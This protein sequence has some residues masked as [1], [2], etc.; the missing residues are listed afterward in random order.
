MIIELD[1]EVFAAQPHALELYQLFRLAFE[2]RHLLLVRP[3][4][5]SG[6]GPA[7]E[8]WLG[9]HDL[10]LRELLQLVLEQ[11]ENDYATGPS[12]A[13]QWTVRVVANGGRAW[14]VEPPEL[15]LEVACKLAESP[16]KILVENRRNDAAFLRACAPPSLRDRLEKVERDGWLEF[17]A[18]GGL[19]EMI[20]RVKDDGKFGNEHRA[21]RL[22][23][24]Y[25]SD[26]KAKYDHET[27]ETAHDEGRTK[28]GPSRDARAMREACARAA[29][30]PFVHRL[31]R[32]AIENYIPGR[33]LQ[34]WA[35]GDRQR[36]R[37]VEAFL[38]MTEEQRH[39]FNMK[40]GL[41]GDAASGVSPIYAGLSD[42]DQAALN[43]GFDSLADY[44]HEKKSAIDPRW[45]TDGQ[46]DELRPLVETIIGLV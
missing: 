27:D 39:Y 9:R 35:K 45:L 44:F 40:K 38:R 32:R 16:L 22:A 26:A 12:P 7:L 43:H 1:D 4:R 2:R 33:V 23:I 30:R 29:G 31:H 24:I 5:G 6:S 11:S 18:G 17:E 25:D 36:H 21:A 15:S 37:R 28:W 42:R 41:S 14:S 3:A 13:H 10:E 46:H 19:S 34:D 20:P 8:R